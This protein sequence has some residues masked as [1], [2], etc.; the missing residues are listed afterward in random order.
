ME[1]QVKGALAG[2]WA[3]EMGQLMAELGA[4]GVI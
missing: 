4:E 1:S 3:I 2:L